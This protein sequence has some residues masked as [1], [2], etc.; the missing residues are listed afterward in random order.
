[1]PALYQISMIMTYF[2]AAH[3]PSWVGALPKG[4]RLR[5]AEASGKHRDAS[6][7]ATARHRRPRTRAR[8]G[9]AQPVLAGK[10]VDPSELAYIVGD[11]A[12][13]EGN[14]LSGDEQIVAADRLASLFETGAE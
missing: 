1:M 3:L 10:I 6:Q 7:W 9:P 8:S 4:A 11:D 14:G 2:M 12:M 5:D 13:A